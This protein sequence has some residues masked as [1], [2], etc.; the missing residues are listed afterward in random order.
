MYSIVAGDN[1]LKLEINN[2]ESWKM[3][4]NISNKSE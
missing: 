2:E 4:V 1:G 3:V